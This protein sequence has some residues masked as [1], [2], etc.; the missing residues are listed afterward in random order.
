MKKNLIKAIN[1][2]QV[3]VLALVLFLTP[4][5]FSSYF[6]VSFET[7]KVLVFGFLILISSFLLFFEFYIN[8]ESFLKYKKK[9]KENKFLMI[10]ILIFLSSFLSAVFSD[11]FFLSFFGSS[12]RHHGILTLFFYLLFFYL[13]LYHLQKRHFKEKLIIVASSSIVLVLIIGFLQCFDLFPS[14][15]AKVLFENIRIFSTL[16]HPNILAA[17]L[18]LSLAYFHLFIEKVF[19]KYL[20][21]L[22]VLILMILTLSRFGFLVILIELF[23]FV[24]LD[25]KT[26]KYLKRFLFL[27]FSILSFCILFFIK[28]LMVLN[29]FF[30]FDTLLS[31]FYLFKAGLKAF[32]RKPFLGYGHDQFMRIS[33]DFL[34][35]DI[36]NYEKTG[37]IADRAHNIFIDSLLNGGFIY[38]LLF[39]LFYY[40][41]AKHLFKQ[42]LTKKQKAILIALFS[43]F[44]FVQFNFLT[45]VLNIYIIFLLAVLL[46]DT[47]EKAR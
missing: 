16:G 5:I 20:L 27:F 42:A 3:I 11:D 19:P 26:S 44:L 37:K 14:L 25:F 31:R 47:L 9:L 36:Y 2:I 35:L 39:V 17:F 34:S 6:D 15:R 23:L 22:L 7:P 21:F 1:N 40:F 32:S 13:L 28:N 38:V 8:R 10:P 30:N 4:I 12:N 43:L 29:R 33:S 46:I 45:I 18:V 24:I 41:L